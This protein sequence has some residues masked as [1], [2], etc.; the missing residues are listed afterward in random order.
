M[1]LGR[2]LVLGLLVW[3]GF[4]LWRRWRRPGNRPAPPPPATKVVKCIECGVYV[5]ASE[6]VAET[7]GFVCQSHRS[8]NRG[9]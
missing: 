4:V 3:A 7:R 1:G 9:A 2:L 5:P 6:A 8:A